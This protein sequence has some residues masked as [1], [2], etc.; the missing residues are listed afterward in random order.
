[1]AKTETKPYDNAR[2]TITRSEW[3][4]GG[5]NGA[6]SLLNENGMCCLGFASKQIGGLKDHEIRDKGCP[7]Y[8]RNSVKGNQFLDLMAAFDETRQFIQFEDPFME[9][10]DA[11]VG[12]CVDSVARIESEEHREQLLT[13]LFA[14]LGI[15]VEFVD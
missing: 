7:S 5:S 15:V 8:V 4:R 14:E 12:Q 3:N 11:L 1:M 10:N 9:V 2:L 6:T 13:D